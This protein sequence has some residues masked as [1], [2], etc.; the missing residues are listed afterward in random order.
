MSN[1]LSES[2]RP[3]HSNSESYKNWNTKF[4]T[5]SGYYATSTT[6]Y[7]TTDVYSLLPVYFS[8]LR[9]NSKIPN[10]SVHRGRP[11]NA[12]HHPYPMPQQPTSR[13]A[14]SESRHRQRTFHTT[15]G[16]S[17]YA[18]QAPHY[19]RHEYPFRPKYSLCCCPAFV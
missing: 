9:S 10:V 16:E 7:K 17:T 14:K 4:S 3:H 12:W 11:Y 15:T 18:G 2:M 13:N 6:T 1:L 8:V 5:L 19:V